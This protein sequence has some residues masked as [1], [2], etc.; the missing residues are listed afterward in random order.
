MT[1]KNVTEKSE[2][3]KIFNTSSGS[4]IVIDFYASWCGP[5]KLI[6][7]HFAK[8][9]QQYTDVVF[10]KIDVDEAEDLA[11]LYDIK[12]MPTFYFIKNNAT[13]AV[14]EGNCVDDIKKNIET[15]K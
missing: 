7:P 5:C 9:A 15:H 6:A 8:M 1:L 12:V 10:I 4:L 2:L 13:L 3:N 11:E 14:L